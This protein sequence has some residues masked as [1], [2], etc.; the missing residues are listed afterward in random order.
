MLKA[1][2]LTGFKS[3][4]DRTRFQ[5]P[6]GVT[7]VVGPNGSGK[8][9]VVDAMKWV[10][11]TQSAKSLRSGEMRDVIFNGAR[12][13]KPLN[14]AEVTLTLDNAKG[15]FQNEG[16]EIQV[17]RRVYRSG[18]TEYLLNRQPCRL[19]DIRDLLSSAG[20]ANEAYG[21][22]EQGKVDAMLQASPNDRRAIFEEAAGINR[23]RTKRQ[24][25]VRRLERVEQNLL[26][27]T[28]IVGEVES[29]LK[30]IRSQAGKAQ[31]YREQTERLQQL[32]TQVGLADWNRFSSE[33]TT[34]NAK[35]HQLEATQTSLLERLAESEASATQIDAK[36][37]QASEEI[38]NR[39]VQIGKIREAL[40]ERKSLCFSF[41]QRI[42]T[43]VSEVTHGRRQLLAMNARTDNREDSAHD[44][45]RQVQLATEVYESA[46]AQLDCAKSVFEQARQQFIAHNA[47]R[48]KLR[49]L[50]AAAT[51]KVT[52]AAQL[53][54]VLRS[55]FETSQS[56]GILSSTEISKLANQRQSIASELR[57][58]QAR[59]AIAVEKAAECSFALTSAQQ[60]LENRRR[61]LTSS[62]KQ[63]AAVE[64]ELSQLSHRGE[65]LEEQHRRVGRL[66]QDLQLLMANTSLPDG[67]ELFQG[68]VADIVNVDVDLAPL[69]ETALGE[70]ARDIILTAGNELLLA[71][72]N[73]P[74][75]KERLVFSRL[76]WR[77]P[78]S[79]VDRVNLLGEP[80]VL[81]R[82]DQFVE[83]EDAFQ[84]LIRR[85]LGRTWIVDSLDTAIRMADSIGKGLH[86]VTEAGD[87]LSADGTIAIGPRAEAAGLLTWRTELQALQQQ[88][89]AERERRSE[90]HT[91]IQ[92]LEADADRDAAEVQDRLAAHAPLAASV[93]TLGQQRAAL[94]ER[95]DQLSS[96]LDRMAKQEDNRRADLVRI[97]TELTA[98]TAEHAHWQAEVNRMSAELQSVNARG[99][100]FELRCSQLQEATTDRQVAVAKAEQHLEILQSQALQQQR[101]QQEREDA[102][103]ECQARLE[104][105]SGELHRQELELLMVSTS[106]SELSIQL[107][108]VVI[109]LREIQACDRRLRADR[110]QLAQQIQRQR[111]EVEQFVS[112]RQQVEMTI[113]QLELERRTLAQRL[114]EDF[115]IDLAAAAE[116]PQPEVIEIDATRVELESA[117]AELRSSLK[118]IGPVNLDAIEELEA[119]ESRFADLSAQH[120]DLTL[121]KATI[122][123]LLGRINNE[124]RELFVV[125]L[126][127]I[128]GHFQELFRRLFGGGEA[129]LLL[130]SQEGQDVL[131]SGVEITAC[132]PGKETRTIS[133]LSGGEKTLTCIALLLAVFRSRPSPF[134]ILDEVD[135]ALDEANIGRFTG[136]LSEFLSSTQFVVVTHSKRTMAGAQ[137]L[138][139]VTMQESGISKQIA[140]KLDEVDD[141]G[142]IRSSAQRIAA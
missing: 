94:A 52:A 27:L 19:R 82:A 5:F 6:A 99:N 59:E 16:A 102:R 81:G 88:L 50:L 60:R 61:D 113:N 72:A 98:T 8:S 137:T 35:L 15:L 31:R 18:E 86:F 141:E 114:Q 104:R 23:F 71:L 7:V 107:E 132:P 89:E 117:I 134:C 130:V 56:T 1:L 43:L 123:Q 112:R 120:R 13:R 78:A 87:Y 45:A 139:G 103:A 24:E 54:Q 91:Q 22:I 101:D 17:T 142:N 2:E 12:S 124:T 90:L 95:H 127:T 97:E 115:G 4:A 29:R 32:R 85:L 63:L 57:E 67:S 80:G 110:S 49:Q 14:A 69:V 37:A 100:E 84:P 138:L 48:E 106:V 51:N 118:G 111:R 129:D 26:R 33:L 136:V 68:Q 66:E 126:E 3:F 25:A 73:A 53:E 122:E 128:R 92:M 105:T 62:H 47:E 76:D 70:R 64:A 40:A 10:L 135:A 42:E 38:R 55:R 9:N 109:E 133:L 75:L 74:D 28:D 34:F 65:L 79:A 46:L 125:T 93:A 116:Q 20:I 11:G 83:T 96:Q 36:L 21:I 30:S 131:E 108:T 140:V 41:T 119:L 77:N 39:E 58:A 44:A 121:A